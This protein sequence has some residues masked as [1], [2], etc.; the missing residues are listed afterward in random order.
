VG[1]D[2]DLEAVV[3]VVRDGGGTSGRS[4]P[5]GWPDQRNF[6]VEVDSEAFFLRLS[7]KDVALGSA[8]GR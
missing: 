7:H 5:S 2:P 3:A 4:P 8:G 6:R 1:L